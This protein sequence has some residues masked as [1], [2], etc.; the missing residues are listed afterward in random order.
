MQPFVDFA[1]KL[2]NVFIKETFSITNLFNTIIGQL[3][4]LCNSLIPRRFKAHLYTFRNNIGDSSKCSKSYFW[5]MAFKVS[6]QKA[7]DFS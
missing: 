6:I 1:V 3:V 4:N 7:H 5:I 2:V